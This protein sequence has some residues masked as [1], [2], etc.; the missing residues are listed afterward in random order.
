M[1]KEDKE[2]KIKVTLSLS[3]ETVDL[4]DT[5]AALSQLSRSGLV[6][7]LVTQIQNGLSVMLKAEEGEGSGPAG[8]D[9]K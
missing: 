5:Y 8:D 1:G 6:G 3:P 4:L 9:C 2:G 7:L